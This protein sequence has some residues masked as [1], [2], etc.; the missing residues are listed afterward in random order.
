[1]YGF[2][3]VG[4][5]LGGG[6]FGKFGKDCLGARAHV[7]RFDDRDKLRLDRDREYEASEN[8]GEATRAS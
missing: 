6:D 3:T 1:M 2:L 8:V 7:E 5:S 4:L